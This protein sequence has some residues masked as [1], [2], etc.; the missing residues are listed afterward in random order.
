[1]T[2]PEPNTP[3]LVA[4][5]QYVGRETDPT[6]ALSPA[7]MLA[8]VAR[9]ALADAGINADA[10][11]ALAIIRLFADSGADAFASPFG[12]YDNLPWSVANRLGHIPE[13]LIYGPVG[14]NT[15][16]M[17][18]NVLAER[19]WR[20]E[21]GVALIAGG[22]ALRTQAMAAKAKLDL[23]WGET[24]PS[25]AGPFGDPHLDR[26]L[27][28]HEVKHGIALPVNVYPLFETAFGAARNWSID[29]HMVEIGRLMAPFTE[30]AAANPHAQVRTARTA[31]ELTI[32]T[33]ENRFIS[34]P[35]TKY[36]VSNMFVDQAAAI[37]LM[38]HERADEFGVPQDARVYLHGSADTV[39]KTPSARADLSRCP[40]I[41]VGAGRALNQAG[42]APGDLGP[43]DLYSCFPIAVEIAARE[44]GIPTD[45]PRGLTLT[46]GLPYFG[47]AGNAYSMHGIAEMVDACRDAPAAH[48]LVFANGGYLSKH[49][50]GVYSARPGY[51]PRTDPA[52]Y[53]TALDAQPSPPLDEAPSGTGRIEAYTVAHDRNGP[54]AAIIIAR[55]DDRRFLARMTAG[56][57]DLMTQNA[58]GL[59][60]RV[61]A[62]SPVNTARLV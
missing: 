53:Q 42:I 12:K 4:A 47:G 38:S 23:D 57:D 56:L 13:D 35:Y 41:A 37:L 17:L 22:E 5:A 27:T 1:M 52:S 49:S 44:I 33:P 21:A 45:D 16:Q 30:V 58:V 2:T 15:P 8:K 24:A 43:L 28:R 18:V 48:G 25:P 10:L 26:L 62:G 29:D 11:D 34:W 7:D 32:A 59:T 19:I 3:C 9:D 46:G 40:A 14:G 54:T 39:E 60:T 31:G 36:L 20:G 61:E 50:F 51:A 55:D 6:A